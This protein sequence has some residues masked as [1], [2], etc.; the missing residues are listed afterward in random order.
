MPTKFVLV[1]I[2]LFS[3]RLRPCCANT[4]HCL[5][6]IGLHGCLGSPNKHRYW[7]CFDLH[8]DQAALVCAYVLILR[9]LFPLVQLPSILFVYFIFIS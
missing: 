2:C 5:D 9:V 6:C 8:N 7:D 3:F 4:H 1:G